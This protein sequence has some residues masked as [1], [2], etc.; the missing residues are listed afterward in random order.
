MLA[1]DNNI[2][3]CQL[4]ENDDTL[5]WNT[6]NVLWMFT[7][8]S[9]FGNKTIVTRN[10]GPL[11]FSDLSSWPIFHSETC[12]D[13]LCKQNRKSWCFCVFALNFMLLTLGNM[14]CHWHCFYTKVFW[15]RGRIVILVPPEHESFAATISPL[16]TCIA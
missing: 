9:Y 14:C 10:F 8:S 6:L 7:C 4:R 1:D 13:H 15:Y 2:P 3:Q 11:F 5:Q 16:E 12:D